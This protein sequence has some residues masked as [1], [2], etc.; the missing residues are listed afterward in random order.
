[1]T[2]SCLIMKLLLFNTIVIIVRWFTRWNPGDPLEL[3]AL[4][5]LAGSF[6]GVPGILF[7]FWASCCLL[8]Y[9]L[10]SGRSM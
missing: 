2:A 3:F 4:L 7:R 1:M 10:E 8:V 6:A 9:L 5:L